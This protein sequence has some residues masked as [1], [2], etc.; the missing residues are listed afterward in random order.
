[1]SASTATA[2]ATAAKRIVVVAICGRKRVG[3]DTV[4]DHIVAHHGFR[5]LSIADPLKD[6]C[7]RAFGLTLSDV[8]T[9]AKDRPHPKLHGRT[10]RQLL[11]FFGTEMMQF[12]LQEFMPDMG[13]SI[14]IDRAIGDIVQSGTARVV[15]PDVRFPHEVLALRAAGF[16]SVWCVRL[17][18]QGAA[19]DTHLSESS[20][21]NM[22][23]DHY[24]ANDGCIQD[25]YAQVEKIVPTL[26][27]DTLA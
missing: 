3:K 10:P 5:K 19:V 6:V 1:M 26:T 24:I 7:C 13:R 23:C 2:T 9:A 21:D 12:K 8:T 14:W 22:P 11:Q 20:I 17:T 15:I 27:E 4:A 18:R 25:L 16:A